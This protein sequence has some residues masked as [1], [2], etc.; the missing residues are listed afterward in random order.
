M[1]AAGP[2]GCDD[3]VMLFIPVR[4]A[5]SMAVARPQWDSFFKEL[6]PHSA[7]FR[8]QVAITP[9]VT[10]ESIYPLA[11]HESELRSRIVAMALQRRGY[12]KD[13]R[14]DGVWRTNRYPVLGFEYQSSWDSGIPLRLLLYDTA[15]REAHGIQ[16][17]TD[18]VRIILIYFGSTLGLTRTK[19][20]HGK[21][22]PPYNTAIFLDLNHLD[23]NALLSGDLPGAPLGLTRRDASDVSVFLAVHD[24]IMTEVGKEQTRIRLLVALFC[25]SMNK[26]GMLEALE[27]R[28]GMNDFVRENLDLYA[29]RRQ[30]SDQATEMGS[31]IRDE[32]TRMLPR[33]NNVPLGVV[34]L[35]RSVP[36]TLIP[37]LRDLVHRALDDG[38]WD[39]V[40]NFDVE[41][42]RPGQ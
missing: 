29:R 32:W 25:A 2:P 7:T 42:I 40:L 34:D 22:L 10:E 18:A 33:I 9:D 36:D 5:S 41:N 4:F 15:L 28:V 1:I 3:L 20:M 19:R 37:S 38:N 35:I 6:A 16:P 14:L 21:L 24:P 39:P 12:W 30:L 31:Q 27:R 8:R 11:A 13:Y 17:A 23:G 26:Q